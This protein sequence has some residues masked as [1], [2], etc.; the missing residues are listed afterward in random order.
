MTGNMLAYRRL[1]SI[2]C[3][4]L[5]NENL[6]SGGDSEW[7]IRAQ[8]LGF[9]IQYGKNV[10]IN[11]PARDD[12]SLLVSKSR[13]L[14]GHVRGGKFHENIYIFKLLLPPVKSF[15]WSKGK[16]VNFRLTAFFVKYYLNL[17]QFWESICIIFFKK[18]ASRV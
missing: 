14:A 15:R 3:V 13:R 9:K 7:S 5:F 10:I 18:N 2:D 8:K 12:F 17:V 4:G 16:P 1:F 6:Y 11:H